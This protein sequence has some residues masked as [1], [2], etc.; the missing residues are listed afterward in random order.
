MPRTGAIV[1]RSICR[2]PTRATPHTPAPTA[3]GPTGATR[4]D[5][6]ASREGA[7]RARGRRGRDSRASGMTAR[8]LLRRCAGR[9][10]NVVASRACYFDD[11]R[12][13]C[14]SWSARSGRSRSISSLRP[15]LDCRARRRFPPDD[16]DRV[17]RDASEPD[18]GRQR[19]RGIAAIIPFLFFRRGRRRQAPSQ[20]RDVS[21][22]ISTLNFHSTTVV[23]VYQRQKH[24]TRPV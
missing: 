4:T 16:E 9:A 6:P 22:V 24:P 19:H 3:P 2:P 23:P 20:R 7:R 1:P 14:Q 18:V 12:S 11:A 13:G 10:I 21:A 15:D 5:V 8:E 17:G